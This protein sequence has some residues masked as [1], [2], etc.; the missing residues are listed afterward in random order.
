MSQKSQKIKKGE[1]ALLFLT[2][3]NILHR[4]NP[5]LQK[6][7]D[8]TN[9]Y[10]HP[11][12]PDK[13]TD[14]Y[15]EKIIPIRVETDWGKDTIVIATLLL[16]QQAYNNIDNK[17]F[18]L[19]SEDIFPLKTYDDFSDYLGKQPNSLFSTMNGSGLSAGIF[20][21]QQWWAL[22]RNDVE[23]LMNALN[24]LNYTGK[25]GLSFTSHIRKQPVFKDIQKAIPKKAA[26][27]ELF[28]L[29]AF[30]K[31]SNDYAFTDRPICYTKWFDWISKHPAIF[32]RLLPSDK[33]AIDDNSCMFVRKTFPTFTNI[34]ITPKHHCVIMVIGTKN[35]GITDY[36]PFI[37]K[38]SELCDIYLLVMIDGVSEISS[39]IK[40]ACVQCYSVVWNQMEDAISKLKTTMASNYKNVVVIPEETTTIETVCKYM[41][42]EHHSKTHNRSY[43]YNKITGKSVWVEPA[44]CE[45]DIAQ[46]KGGTSTMKNRRRKNKTQKKK[47]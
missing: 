6:Y 14:K 37:S 28:F 27:D 10:I 30:K 4:N 42:D 44:T 26:M 16:L 7:L 13:I 32:N 24:L 19:C 12:Y 22:T 9:I 41:W 20:K 1:I 25:D 31:I 18:V 21:S 35:K 17:W 38:Y 2:Y 5:V 39:D 8:N 45:E 43:W 23:L 36:T 33:T 15:V 29:S 34:V 46:K 40:Q 47:A 3:E 11:K